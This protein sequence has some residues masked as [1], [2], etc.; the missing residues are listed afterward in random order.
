MF[1]KLIIFAILVLLSIPV[2][3]Q[4]VGTAWVRRYNGPGNND[5]I[6]TD[7]TVDGSGN[8]YVTGQSHGSGTNYDYATI[9]YKPNGDTAW[10]RRYNGLDN[11]DDVAYAIAVDG[12]GNVCVTGFSEGSGTSK[13]FVTIKYYAN[14]DTTWVRR[15]NGLDNYDDRAWDICLDDSGRVYVTGTTGYA[16]GLDD[17]LTI[18]YYPNGD[19][20]WLRTYDGSGNGYDQP[21]A[22]TVDDSMVC[23]LFS[24]GH[25]SN[26]PRWRFNRDRF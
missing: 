25:N 23:Y 2:F 15:Y 13:D 24:Y 21:S 4:V 14:G 16:T 1:K 20:A 19:T 10:V 11:G 26:R 7:I 12:S 6:A 17:F 8:V 5:D 18:A 9:K 3:A 22:V